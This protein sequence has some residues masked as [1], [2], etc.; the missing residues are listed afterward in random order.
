MIVYGYNNHSKN[1]K[2]DP[3]SQANGLR[4]TLLLYYIGAEGIVNPPLAKMRYRSVGNLLATQP[5]YG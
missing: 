5:P 4:F 3:S 2:V 1:S